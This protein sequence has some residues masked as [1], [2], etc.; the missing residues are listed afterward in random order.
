MNLLLMVVFFSTV[1]LFAV[2][3][4]F[5]LFA[6][7]RTTGI[8]QFMSGNRLINMLGN[9]DDIFPVN[10]HYRMYI[11]NLP[12]GV[13]IVNTEFWITYNGLAI[14]HLLNPL[15]LLYFIICPC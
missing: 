6:A 9:I 4:V 14:I 3:I 13:I 12:F 7:S 1:V 2:F 5:I 8:N 11:W 15:C 10:M